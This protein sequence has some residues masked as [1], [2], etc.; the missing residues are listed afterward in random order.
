[1]TVVVPDVVYQPRGADTRVEAGAHPLNRLTFVPS[2][3]P[4]LPPFAILSLDR[5]RNRHHVRNV[6]CAL[7][8]V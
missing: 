7:H 3:S 2:G 8:P 4:D 1:V 5:D 6:A